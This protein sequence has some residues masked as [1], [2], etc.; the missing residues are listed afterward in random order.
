ML[1]L[2]KG[3]SSCH[4][5]ILRCCSYF[6]SLDT[7]SSLI[8]WDCKSVI[9][10]FFPENKSVIWYIKFDLMQQFSLVSLMYALS[11]TRHLKLFWLFYQKKNSWGIIIF[12]STIW[13]IEK[14]LTQKNEGQVLWAWRLLADNKIY[15]YYYFTPFLFCFGLNH[16]FIITNCLIWSKI[17]GKG[18]IFKH[19][20][21][22]RFFIYTQ[23]ANPW[24][25][26]QSIW[27][28][29]NSLTLKPLPLYCFEI[30]LCGGVVELVSVWW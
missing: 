13:N 29:I 21:F 23:H 2:H 15:Y 16:K 18:S 12:W 14:L 7:R 17:F 4:V 3:G 10:F 27:H 9:L 25:L 8:V 22:V 1:S 28:A 24:I 20:R 30:W 6:F 19:T 11:F 5:E 26:P